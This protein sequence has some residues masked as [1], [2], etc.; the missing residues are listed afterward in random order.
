MEMQLEEALG[1]EGSH[2]GQT[3]LCEGSAGNGVADL[4]DVVVG[5][6]SAYFGTESGETP[7]DTGENTPIL[8]GTAVNPRGFPNL[9]R[10]VNLEHCQR[11]PRLTVSATRP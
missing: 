2:A 8:T 7:V 3:A 6:K 4:R 9:N 1:L 11:T 5:M 10:L